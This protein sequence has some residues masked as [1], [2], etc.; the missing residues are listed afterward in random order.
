MVNLFLY[1]LEM[2]KE[3]KLVEEKYTVDETNQ[4]KL[5]P[6]KKWVKLVYGTGDFSCK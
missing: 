6:L 1:P 2:E 4:M 3:E 5:P